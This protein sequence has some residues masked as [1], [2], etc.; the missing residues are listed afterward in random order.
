MV[1]SLL[2]R[3]ITV[4]DLNTLALGGM[5][6]NKRLSIYNE[7]LSYG[8]ARNSLNDCH[9]KYMLFLDQT[10]NFSVAY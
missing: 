3:F 6:L 9:R 5:A 10:T 8:I 7:K 2:F 4:D 1:K